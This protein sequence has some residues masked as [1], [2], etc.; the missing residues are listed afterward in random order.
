MTYG[1]M[2]QNRTREK[3]FGMNV[4][5]IIVTKFHKVVIKITGI[6]N[7]APPKV[8]K[9]YERM[10]ITFEGIFAVWTIIEH[11]ADILVVYSI[12]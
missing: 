4:F 10:T 12:L 8:S 3:Y 1:D 11:E 9:V 2:D 5:N 6:R 7:R